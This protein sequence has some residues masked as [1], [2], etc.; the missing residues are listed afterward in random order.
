MSTFLSEIHD[1]KSVTLLLIFLAST[2]YTSLVVNKQGQ[3]S[4]K[5]AIKSSGPFE[6]KSNFAGYQ[7]CISKIGH[8]NIEKYCIFRLPY[9]HNMN[10]KRW[11]QANF[12]SLVLK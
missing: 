7:L 10:C 11:K 6:W 3:K 5:T 2:T 1:P 8:T 4:M 9:G 12:W